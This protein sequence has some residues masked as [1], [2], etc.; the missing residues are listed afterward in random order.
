MADGQKTIA[1]VVVP[2][3][4][5]G[6]VVA[7]GFLLFGGKAKPATPVASPESTVQ[8]AAGTPAGNTAGATP[9]IGGATSAGY[10]GPLSAKPQPVEP[11]SV[12]GGLDASN[13]QSPLML[14]A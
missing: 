10:T 5:A 1:R 13:L 2:A 11:W 12:I 3:V 6:L 7:L 9:T 8:P 4:M 14:S